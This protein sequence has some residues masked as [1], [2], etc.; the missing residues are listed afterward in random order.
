MKA[1]GTMLV[2]GPALSTST[3]RLQYCRLLKSEVCGLKCGAGLLVHVV[4]WLLSGVDA[5]SW[6]RSAE[7][8]TTAQ[9][10]SQVACE[11]H[12]AH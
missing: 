7:Q 5:H 3:T 12:P 6:T 8:L 11:Q 1:S 10:T 9:A 4:W 2:R